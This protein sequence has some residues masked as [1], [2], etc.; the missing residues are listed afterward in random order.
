MEATIRLLFPCCYK[1]LVSVL[2]FLFLLPSQVQA[3]IFEE[4]KV[5]PL[6]YKVFKDYNFSVDIDSILATNGLFKTPD[7]IGKF[8]GPDESFWIQVDFKDE[9]DTL[10]TEELWRLR[11]PTFGYADL[12]YQDQD[13]VS[14]VT[15][16]TFNMSED[17]S[18]M[19]YHPGVSFTKDNLINGRYLYLRTCIFNYYSNIRNWK[20][21]YLSDASNKYYTHYYTK[22]DVQILS[23]DYLYLG[24]CLI[25]FLAFFAI[26]LYTRKLQFLFYALYII[27]SVTYL[28]YPYINSA[29][30][31]RITSTFLGH[32]LTSICQVLINLFYVCFV[33]YYLNTKKNYPILH[34]SILVIVALLVGVFVVDGYVFLKGYYPLHMD[35]LSF[36][37]LL[38]TVWGLLAMI[39]LLYKAKDKLA[40][41]VVAGSFLYMSGALAYLFLDNRFYMIVGSI[42]EILVFTLGLAY[43]I[44][45]EF[46]AKIVLQNEVSIK[47]V[48][49]LRAQMNPHF[50]FNSL[51]SIQHLILNNDR[52][53]ALK[54][55]SKFG[56][57]TRNVLESSIETQSVLRKEIELLK[58]Y[59]ELE[60]LRFEGVFKYEIHVDEDLDTNNV[61]IPLLL[62]QPYVENAILHGLLPKKKDEKLLTISFERE[63]NNII[64]SIE[65]NGVGRAAA[66]R[67]STYSKREKKSRGME[68]TGKRLELLG[69]SEL[70]RN[71]VEITDKFDSKGHP[72]GTKVVIRIFDALKTAV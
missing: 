16:G 46:E 67:T 50:I 61:E 54:Y 30:A 58:S 63:K 64:C 1:F 4:R 17:F 59:L 53:M 35:V 40:Y 19:L 47:E 62:V 60:S 38:M 23:N 5:K 57:L 27:T 68:I 29:E 65:D 25:L 21:G 56:K 9:V 42:L 12:F 18:S 69:Q 32:W 66:Q 24:A 13:S 11:T 15:F 33:I 49:A 34:R 36:Q 48:S 43:K 37:R 45:Q 52:V 10:S 14:Q 44:K 39:Y 2:L 7:Q 8:M 41:F 28:T 55:L 72:A 70:G 26:F 20:L 31:A 3:Q 71:S 51:N 22:Q 6:S